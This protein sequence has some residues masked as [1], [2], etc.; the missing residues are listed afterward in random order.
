MTFLHVT[1][2]ITKPDA[3]KNFNNVSW[4]IPESLFISFIT[5]YQASANNGNLLKTLLT[6]TVYSLQ[7]PPHTISECAVFTLGITGTA[8]KK[9]E[10]E[11]HSVKSDSGTRKHRIEKR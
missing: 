2:R 1:K 3:Q 9:G 6:D 11:P 5:S 7:S 10:A 8:L 4:T